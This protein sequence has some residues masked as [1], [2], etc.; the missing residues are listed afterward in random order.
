MDPPVVL[1]VSVL[2]R[3]VYEDVDEHPTYGGQGEA[4]HEYELGLSHVQAAHYRLHA[5]RWRWAR[6]RACLLAR[7]WPRR[8]TLVGHGPRAGGPYITISQ[9][10]SVILLHNHC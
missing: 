4:A 1:G 8:R 3:Q 9:L 7:V 6:R 5:A 2:A 10:L